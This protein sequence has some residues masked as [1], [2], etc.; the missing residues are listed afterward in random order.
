MADIFSEFFPKTN[1]FFVMVILALKANLADSK[2]KTQQE[3]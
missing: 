2:K 3:N 1:F